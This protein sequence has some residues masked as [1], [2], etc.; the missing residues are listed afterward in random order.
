VEGRGVDGVRPGPTAQLQRDRGRAEQAERHAPHH[1]RLAAAVRWVGTGEE[2]VTH[3]AFGLLSYDD[4][5]KRYRFQGFTTRGKPRGH[6]GQGHGRATVWEMKVPQFGDL[7]Y[8]VKLDDKRSVFDVGEVTQK[9]KVWRKCFEIDAGKKLRRS[10]GGERGQVGLTSVG[11]CL[12]VRRLINLT[13]FLL[14]RRDWINTC[15]CELG[16]PD[17]A[18]DDQPKRTTPW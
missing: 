12:L 2:V 5:A 15:S 9:G 18:I 11:C 16:T 1:R 6:G 4:K 13:P 3:N 14:N 8:T 17:G 10:E 7:R